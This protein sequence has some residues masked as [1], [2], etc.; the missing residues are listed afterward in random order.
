MLL[1][2]ISIIVLANMAGE[3]KPPSPSP[4]VFDQS[5]AHQAKRKDAIQRAIGAGWFGKVT[6]ASGRPEAWVTPAFMALDF[7]VKRA[8]LAGVY[9]YYFDGSAP[10]RRLFLID[11]QT[12]RK[13]GEFSPKHGLKLTADKP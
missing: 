6:D 2:L 8:A 12:G 10:Y 11:N 4:P 1:G 7:D 5:P 3:T 13:V 9:G